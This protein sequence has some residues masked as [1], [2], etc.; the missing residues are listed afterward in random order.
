MPTGTKWDGA[1]VQRK[2]GS[3]PTLSAQAAQGADGTERQLLRVS[4]RRVRVIPADRAA[5]AFPAVSW[6]TLPF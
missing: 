2:V 4:S 5:C 3:A 1:R 6:Q